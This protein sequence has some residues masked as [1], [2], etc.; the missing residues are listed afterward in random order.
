MGSVV[1]RSR[2]YARSLLGDGRLRR[3]ETRGIEWIGSQVHLVAVV[4]AITVG[5]GVV[6]VRPHGRLIDVRQAVTIA[7][8]TDATGGVVRDHRDTF[9]G[10]EWLGLSGRLNAPIRDTI[11][12][13]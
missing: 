5:I 9:L 4:V 13:G 7:V 1:W 3:R 10:E 11:T 2:G 8:D 12:V 6:R